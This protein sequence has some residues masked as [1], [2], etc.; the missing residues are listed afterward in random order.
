LILSHT[1]KAQ[2]KYRS[3]VH[4]RLHSPRSRRLTHRP[5]N[6]VLAGLLARRQ[7]QSGSLRSSMLPE[8]RPPPLH[9]NSPLS[10]PGGE[11]MP[12]FPSSPQRSPQIISASF[13]Q[14][15]PD[16][17]GGSGMHPLHLPHPGTPAEGSEAASPRTESPEITVRGSLLGE[18][19]VHT[20]FSGRRICP[21][22]NCCRAS[23]A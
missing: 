17:M 18:C 1:S 4:A 11:V 22:C 9:L 12:A 10:S 14:P 23:F 2:T 19:C 16:S 3:L 5:P 8:R 7:T 20:L 21:F 13:G 6:I 15:R